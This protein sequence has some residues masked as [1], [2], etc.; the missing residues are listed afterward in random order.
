MDPAFFKSAGPLR[1]LAGSV[2]EGG[3]RV[4]MIVRWPAK[5]TAGQVS[6]FAWTACD[7]LP[8]AAEIAMVEPPKKTDGISVLPTLL[9]QTQTNRHE[10]FRWEAQDGGV[11]QQA[12]RMGDWKGVLIQTNST[13]S[14]LELYDLKAD[15]GERNNV[16]EE[17]PDVAAKM[18]KLLAPEPAGPVKNSPDAGQ[19]GESGK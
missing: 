7:F 3:I 15:V 8:T 16:A 12:V 9:G 10:I 19:G 6:D 18:K 13:P 1:G 2:Y 5:I 11:H 14:H 4:P 17:H